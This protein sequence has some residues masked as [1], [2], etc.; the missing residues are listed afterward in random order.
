MTFQLRKVNVVD[1][2]N[3]SINI[4]IK[5]FLFNWSKNPSDYVKLRQKKKY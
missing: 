1:G 3:T 4:H 5:I 2:I